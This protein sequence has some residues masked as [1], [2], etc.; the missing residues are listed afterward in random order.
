MSNGTVDTV[1]AIQVTG[2]R[3]MVG[4]YPDG[5]ERVAIS[6]TDLPHYEGSNPT[7]EAG[8]IDNAEL[9]NGINISGYNT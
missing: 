1:D 4:T 2:A 3:I 6:P 5:S 8:F 7:R 9:P